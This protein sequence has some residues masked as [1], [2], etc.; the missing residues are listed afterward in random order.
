MQQV[1]PFAKMLSTQGVAKKSQL[2]RN[3]LIR[4]VVILLLVI[5]VSALFCVWSRVRI[6]QLGY[7][8][9]K[10]GDQAD[11]LMTKQNH[12]Q[13]EVDRLTSPR[14]LQKV[15]VEYLQMHPPSSNEIVFI[16]Y[17]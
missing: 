12:L 14:R 9:S 8:V 15:G 6:I 11:E 3:K 1:M 7:D 16:N 2:E 4:R 17:D 5:T 13:V 10:L